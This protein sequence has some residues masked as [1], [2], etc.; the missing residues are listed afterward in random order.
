MPQACC[1]QLLNRAPL[2]RPQQFPLDATM[3]FELNT[4]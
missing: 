1:Q 2:S 4:P 3:P